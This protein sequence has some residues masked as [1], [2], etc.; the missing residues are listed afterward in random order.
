[1]LPR[2]L[3]NLDVD[4]SKRRWFD[5]GKYAL[6]IRFGDDHAVHEFRWN[7]FLVNLDVRQ[8]PSESMHRGL[9]RE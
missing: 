9:F 8:V 4:I 6:E 1:M 2:H 7:L 3:R 5:F